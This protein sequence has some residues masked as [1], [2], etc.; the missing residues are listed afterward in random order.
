MPRLSKLDQLIAQKEEMLQSHKDNNFSWDR[1]LIKT[2]KAELHYLHMERRRLNEENKGKKND[3]PNQ[4]PLEQT[5]RCNNC[6][7]ANNGNCGSRRDG[8]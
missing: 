8:D 7:C 5:P 6:S 2:L 3:R 4:E 1:D